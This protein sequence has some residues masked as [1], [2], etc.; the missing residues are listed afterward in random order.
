MSGAPAAAPP[1]PHETAVGVNRSAARMSSDDRP[2]RMPSTGGTS[3]RSDNLDDKSI[4]GTRGNGRGPV[5]DI[6][7]LHVDE[8]SVGE[9]GA[10]LPAVFTANDT[11]VGVNRSDARTSSD[12]QPA[13]MPSTVETPSRS[14]NLVDKSLHGTRGN[15]RDPVEDMSFSNV[16]DNTAEEVGA[17]TT[18]LSLIHI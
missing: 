18:A 2:A 7:S 3:S 10:L 5:E 11:A 6:G 15:G 9:V 13:R 1:T 17:P 8:D 16:D 12:D 4:H 14:D